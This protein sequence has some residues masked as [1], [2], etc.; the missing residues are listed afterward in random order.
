MKMKKIE[1]PNFFLFS[2]GP[3]AGKTTVI[4]EL[5]R[6]GHTT[7]PEAARSIIRHQKATGGH[8]TH[9]GNRLA[10]TDL[11]LAKSMED[12]TQL[13]VIDVPIFFDRGLPDLYSYSDRFCGGVTQAV[14]QAI[15]QYR[16]NPIAFIFPPWPEIYCHDT[17][18]K[19]SLEE[20]VETWHAVM[21]GYQ[22]CGYTP[23]EVP[24]ASVENRVEFILTVTQSPH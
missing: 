18:R 21:N 24:K 20:A 1:K 8:A 4:E 10:Y 9:D 23:I 2:G 17:E 7:V 22:K 6:Q 5:K 19:Q 12:F 11:M 3:G 14:E 16:Y 15:Q 13:M